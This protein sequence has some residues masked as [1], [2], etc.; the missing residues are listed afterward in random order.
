MRYALAAFDISARAVHFRYLTSAHAFHNF[1]V[2]VPKS[3]RPYPNP[4][5]H[6]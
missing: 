4:H 1:D 5:A 2:K 3:G 6:I